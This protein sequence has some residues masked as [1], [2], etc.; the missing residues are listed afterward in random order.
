MIKVV[1][2]SKLEAQPLSQPVDLDELELT[3]L[4]SREEFMPLMDCG[5]GGGC[6]TSPCSFVGWDCR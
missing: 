6:G 5:G 1:D 2:F 3:E 4:E